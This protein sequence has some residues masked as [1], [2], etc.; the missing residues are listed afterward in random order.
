MRILLPVIAIVAAVS[1]AAA[2]DRS[3]TVTGFTK[4]RID[5]PYNVKVTTDSA[6]FAR[7]TGEPSALDHLA[8]EVQGN[9]LIVHP[10]RSA[11][12]G[13][14]GQAHTAVEISVGTYELASAWV[15]GAGSVAIDKVRALSF[16]LAVEGP[17]SASI[18]QADVDQLRIRIAGT[19]LA[20]VAGRAPRL[21]AQ[22]RGSSTLDAANLA[23]KDVTIAAEGPATVKI[24]ASSS[25]KV[26]A[27]GTAQVELTGSPACTNRIYGSA[28][29]LGCK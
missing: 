23:S 5:G 16:D 6:P 17:G 24:A 2:A 18:G 1:P 8:I 19:A 10:D 13:F 27:Y 20:T 28:S 22:V 15:N 29:V 26:D 12:G 14:P 7:A 21:T 9:T 4:I 25:A 11:W 3:F